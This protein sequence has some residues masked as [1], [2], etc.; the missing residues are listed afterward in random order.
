VKLSTR[1]REGQ[2]IITK[3]SEPG[4]VP[5]L[6]AVVS[7]VPSEVTAEMMEPGQAN[8]VLRDS[9]L[10]STHRAHVD[11]LGGPVLRSNVIQFWTPE[12]VRL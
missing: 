2:T 5:G 7:G 10:C 11:N 4:Y 12:S 1:S 9:W 6:N 3:I 8:F